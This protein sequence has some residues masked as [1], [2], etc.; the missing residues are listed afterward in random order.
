M[1]T[2]PATGGYW[3]VAA[4]GGVFSYDAPYYGSMGGTPLNQPIVGMAAAPDGNGYWLVARD[5]G[6][7]SFGPS[8]TFH[9]STGGLHLSQ[10]IVGMANQVGKDENVTFKDDI[11]DA[12]GFGAGD[13]R[14]RVMPAP[15][16]VLLLRPRTQFVTEMLKSVEAL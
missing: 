13:V 5:G 8:A 11:L 6:I 1:A 7:F 16:R 4:D 2:D 14:I 15:K 9:G 3:L 10:P 12:H